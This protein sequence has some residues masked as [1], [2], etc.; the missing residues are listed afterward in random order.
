[1]LLLTQLVLVAI[2]LTCEA[3]MVRKGNYN[4]KMK[5]LNANAERNDAMHKKVMENE[6][7]V[8]SYEQLSRDKNYGLA[9]SEDRQ[10]EYEHV[11]FDE[12]LNAEVI[13]YRVQS[14]GVGSVIRLSYTP[15]SQVYFLLLN[16][17]SDSGD[18]LL[19]FN[20]R[21]SASIGGPVLVL[22]SFLNGAWGAEERPAGF[23][24]DATTVYVVVSVEAG[25]Y[26]ITVNGGAFQYLYVHRQ[27]PSEVTSMSTDVTDIQYGAVVSSKN[28][29]DDKIGKAIYIS[30]AI[31]A[32][33]GP[34][35]CTFNV[36]LAP[37]SGLATASP[38]NIALHFNPRPSSPYRAV[39]RNTFINGNWGGEEFGGGLPFT[40]NSP[41]SLVVNMQEDKFSITVNGVQFA[42]FAYRIRLSAPTTVL[43]SPGLFG[44]ITEV[45]V[46]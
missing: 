42:T 37:P 23:P 14:F 3:S 21:Y 32:A 4:A 35:T 39:Y 40:L 9:D 38:S 31:P 11:T 33:P 12:E 20:P 34:S 5:H 43:V 28:C 44:S 29:S 1:M 13:N 15:P 6:N 27:S 30:G 41:Y 19:H 22:N 10:A 17:I 7:S 45:K 16:L 25:G 36:I 8:K 18:I 2:A 46:V 26:R 24:F